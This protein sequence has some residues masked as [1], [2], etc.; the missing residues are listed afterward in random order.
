MKYILLILL[1]GVQ[2]LSA[3][4]VTTKDETRKSEDT[5]VVVSG[6]SD[7][8]EIF[9]PT[10]NDY[11]YQTQFS[12]KKL[13]DTSFSISRSYEF[14]QFNNRDNFGKIQFSNIGSGFQPLIFETNKEQNLSV[15]P[16]NKSFFILGADDIKYYD[17][18]TPTATFIYHNSMKNGAALQ[19]TYTQNVGKNFNFAIEYMGLRSQGL[20]R[21]SLA[22]SNNTIFS[23]HYISKNKKYEAFAHYIHQNVNNEENGGIADLSVFLSGDSRFKN[24]QNLETNLEGVTSR[25][26]YRRYYFSHEFAPLDSEKYPFK[27]RHTISHQGNKYYFN[28]TVADDFFSKNVIKGYSLNSKKYSDNLSNTFSLVW[29]KENFKLDAGVRH[30]NITFGNLY[31][32]DSL[33]IPGKLKENRFGALGNLQIKLWNR[34]QLKSYLEFSNGN[35][36][37]T[38]LKTTNLVEFEPFKDY[39]VDA[40][41]NFQS[42]TPSFNNILNSSNY[43]SYNYYLSDPKN[44]SV[45]ELGAK[46]RLKWF[47]ANVYLNLV[48]VDNYAYFNNQGQSLQASDALN[49]TQVGGEATLR[50]GKFNLN[51]RLHFQNAISGKDY[52]PMP[53]FIGR[54]NLFYQ[55]KAFKDAA[56]IQA[57]IK[58]YYFTKFASRDYSPILN[59]FMLPNDKAYSIGGQPIADAYFNLKVKRM[60]FYIEAQHFNTTFLQNKSYTA[61]YFPIYDFRLNLGI[62]WYL[63]S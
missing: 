57:G 51:G 42:A 46:L 22:A 55:T 1:F 24:R 20:Y 36:F 48:R 4:I 5:L 12:Q 63:F 9:K 37:G 19:S 26:Y 62:V 2:L 47:D 27:L 25:L 61:P 43:A 50:Y 28:Q 56:E 38:F 45:T 33:G 54:A 18:K 29:D 15:L 11:L 17:V 49:I 3:Q 8:L 40:H 10:I 35:T 34:F 13:F 16:T 39:F 58:M 52:Y 23:G 30:Q 21:N 14:T 60:F 31:P 59:E 6:K 44:Q 41:F 32:S 53:S 7:S